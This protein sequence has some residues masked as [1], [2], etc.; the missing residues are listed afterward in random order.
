MVSSVRSLLMWAAESLLWVSQIYEWTRVHI[1]N[2]TRT[3]NLTNARRACTQC[4]VCAAT[5]S[6]SIQELTYKHICVHISL[7]PYTSSFRRTRL[8]LLWVSITFCRHALQR[9]LGSCALLHLLFWKSFICSFIG[10]V[11]VQYRC[12]LRLQLAGISFAFT[13]F[14]VVRFAFKSVLVVVVVF[15]VVRVKLSH[16]FSIYLLVVVCW[17]SSLLSFSFRLIFCCQ[18]ENSISTFFLV[19]PLISHILVSACVD[20]MH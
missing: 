10:F 11:R 20:G 1:V 16:K 5:R 14:L 12:S 8:S 9:Q 15:V 13:Y 18:L 2:Y 7:S 17:P 4:N 19:P 3:L 6:A